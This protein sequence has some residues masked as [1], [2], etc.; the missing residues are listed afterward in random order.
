[1]VIKWSKAS[2]NPVK[3]VKLFRKPERRLRWLTEEECENLI[4]AST[5][6]IRSIVIT[7]LNTGM[8]LG[9]ILKLTWDRVDFERAIITVEKSKNDGICIYL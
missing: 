3:E 2:D 5:G 6:H 7:A 8:R 1:M 4:N 9:E